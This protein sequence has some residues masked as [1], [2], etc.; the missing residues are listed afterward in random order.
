MIKPTPLYRVYAQRKQSHGFTLI[1]LTVVMAVLGILLAAGLYGFNQYIEN[2]N[3]SVCTQQ[4]GDI[5]RAVNSVV[6]IQ[7]VI[8]PANNPPPA[9]ITTIPWNPAPGPGLD[10][11][12]YLGNRTVN[13]GGVNTV[14]CPAGGTYAAPA[15]WQGTTNQP[16]DPTCN[17]PALNPGKFLN[18]RLH[19][20]QPS[21]V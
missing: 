12:P 10:I 8:N 15:G 11:A 9:A 18:T 4:L 19:S 14:T 6:A 3:G 16:Q 20:L 7:N 5:S 13:G 2:A 1:E 21:P 17:F